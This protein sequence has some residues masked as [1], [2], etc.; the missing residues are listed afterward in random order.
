MSPLVTAEVVAGMLVLLALATLTFIFIRRRLLAS[1]SSLMLCA[2]RQH[3]PN[4][5][6]GLLRIAG[7]RLEWFSLVGPSM[8]PRR[9]WDRGRLQLDAP[10]APHEVLAGLPDGVEVTC[11]Y[12]ANTFQLALAP[13]A[14]TAIRSWLESA[15]P[16][17]NVNVA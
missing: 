7:P 13:T 16:G 15:P 4:Y 17:F 6:L 2:L 8:R 14:Y 3:S 12:G 1:Q 11:H 10:G 9:T 5:R